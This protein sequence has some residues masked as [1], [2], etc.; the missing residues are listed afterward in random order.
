MRKLKTLQRNPLATAVGVAV[1]PMLA[2][3]TAQAQLEEVVVTATKQEASL[4]DVAVAVSALTEES[5]NQRGIT[6]FNDYLIELPNVTAGGAGPGQSTM[7]IR[8]VASPT[9]NLTTSGVAGLSP[10]VVRP[11]ARAT[12]WRDGLRTVEL[13]TAITEFH[14]AVGGAGAAGAAS[15]PGAPRSLTIGGL[16]GT[17]SVELMHA[18]EQLLIQLASVSRRVFEP[19][20][21]AHAQYVAQLLTV[22]SRLTATSAPPA[23]GRGRP[24][25]R[26]AVPLAAAGGWSG[27]KFVF[28]G[29]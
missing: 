20:D 2:A 21:T 24:G 10:N 17:S 27:R 29:R 18:L 22:A 7:Y 5:L 3:T 19:L 4:Q 12:G 11:P 28:A 6:N 8:G 26:A 25:R 16:D 15:D 14:A 13:L 1:M 9:P 23:A